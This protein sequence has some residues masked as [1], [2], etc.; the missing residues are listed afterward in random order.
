[1]CGGADRQ[2]RTGPGI[3]EDLQVVVVPAD[4]V[5][6]LDPGG[7]RDA[8]ALVITKTDVAP[9]GLDLGAETGRVR[10]A[11]PELAVFCLAP[12][13]DDRGLD[14]WRTWLE[15]QVLQRGR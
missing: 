10:A 9:E 4:G 2:A 12:G 3:G 13:H 8:Q 14:E 15:G 6:A 1:L 5:E 11:N 7:L